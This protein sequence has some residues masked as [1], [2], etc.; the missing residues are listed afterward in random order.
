MKRP[1]RLEILE[2]ALEGIGT[3]IGIRQWETYD[4]FDC[5]NELEA[6]QHWIQAEIKR[7]KA[8]DSK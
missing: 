5:L 7:A 2:Y 6:H 1:S 3:L 4:D 8:K